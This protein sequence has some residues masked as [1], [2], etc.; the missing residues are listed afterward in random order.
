MTKAEK[1]ALKLY[2]GNDEKN[3][4][5]LFDILDKMDVYSEKEMR[6]KISDIKGSAL[7]ETKRFLQLNIMRTLRMLHSNDE[8]VSLLQQ[9]EDLHI[10]KKKGQNQ[11]AL[12]VI[13][14][15]KQKIS[16]AQRF[17]LMSYLKQIELEIIRT[18]F[19]KEVSLAEMQQHYV[20]LFDSIEKGKNLYQYRE[21]NH[22][23]QFMRSRS[24]ASNRIQ[25]YEAFMEKW[26]H[27]DLF[28]SPKNAKSFLALDQYYVFWLWY[29]EMKQDEKKQ[30]QLIQRWNAEFEK[31]PAYKKQFAVRYIYVLYQLGNAAAIQG[32]ESVLQKSISALEC[33]SSPNSEMEYDRLVYLFSIQNFANQCKKEE[34]KTIALAPL[35]FTI[36]S[37][38]TNFLN[39][40]RDITFQKNL[41]IAF[42][43]NNDYNKVLDYSNTILNE[44]PKMIFTYLCQIRIL[45]ILAHIGLKN[46]LLLETL[47]RSFTYFVNEN[48]KLTE[49]E[50]LIV[51]LVHKIE[52]CKSPKETHRVMKSHLSFFKKHTIEE[53]Q[54]F[55]VKRFLEKQD[56]VLK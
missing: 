45:I 32:N 28:I 29:H 52:K 12:Q 44:Y 22:L 18:R 1:R 31:V 26:S 49:D 33:Y 24:G 19:F 40:E 51:S 6:L 2:A 53:G 10:L 56:D 50:K 46:F 35:Y 15:L 54:Y 13:A 39:A 14:D 8:D 9:I 17:F 38:F 37:S 36:K 25:G 5:R 43:L 47:C 42:L 11:I 34:H 4:I 27:S 48:D 20:A 55:F 7:S 30:L 41:A 16:E 21:P 23:A 3:Y